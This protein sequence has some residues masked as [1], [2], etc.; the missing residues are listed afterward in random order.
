MRIIIPPELFEEN[1]KTKYNLP[2]YLDIINSIDYNYV[3][4]IQDQW[5]SVIGA[6]IQGY[7]SI[8]TP[9]N[10][11]L[12]QFL[13]IK[14]QLFQNTN[15][16]IKVVLKTK[17]INSGI[18]QNYEYELF[19]YGVQSQGIW[20]EKIDRE[21]YNDIRIPEHYS[22]TDGDLV[23]EIQDGFNNDNIIYSA[24]YYHPDS[25]STATGIKEL[26]ESFRPW[27][28]PSIEGTNEDIYSSDSPLCYLTSNIKFNK[29][30]CHSTASSYSPVIYANL[31]LKNNTKN[32]II[33]LS[34][35][36]I[37]ETDEYGT[38]Q[39]SSNTKIKLSDYDIDRNDNIT[40]FFWSSTYGG[41][42]EINIDQLS[43]DYA[44]SINNNAASKLILYNSFTVVK[45]PVIM[46]IKLPNNDIKKGILYCR[47]S[48][49]E[50]FKIATDFYE[51]VDNEYTQKA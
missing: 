28:A 22:Y 33:R 42:P 30:K 40:I 15:N 26:F 46:S 17:V 36:L 13:D 27:L 41:T 21:Y 23:L 1:Y 9:M 8:S 39:I 32:K 34:D 37:T 12:L 44:D 18:E 14:D 4:N 6:K 16:Y 47:P 3:S 38:F 5:Y 50:D 49:E 51:K 43:E 45:N 20:N 31:Y 24:S 19:K 29:I 48:L 11:T 7:L 35:D 25:Y 2:I 10:E